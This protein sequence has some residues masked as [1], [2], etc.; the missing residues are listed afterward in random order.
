MY[1]PGSNDPTQKSPRIIRGLVSMELA[2]SDRPL[3]C[4]LNASLSYGLKAS[5]TVQAEPRSYRRCGIP[6]LSSPDQPYVRRDALRLR[7][8]A[9]STPQSTLR[10]ERLELSFALQAPLHT[11]CREAM[12]CCVRLRNAGITG[13]AGIGSVYGMIQ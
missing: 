4:S 12:A 9:P 13:I 3:C 1:S 10:L 5:P 6:D 2:I 11:T 7:Q 8:S